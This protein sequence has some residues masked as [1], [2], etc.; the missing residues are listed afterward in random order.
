MLAKRLLRRLARARFTKPT[1]Q[2]S[3]LLSPR[4]VGTTVE[5]AE[6]GCAYLGARGVVVQVILSA[7]RL[8]EA[9]GVLR[10]AERLPL[11]LE[12]REESLL[13]P[14]TERVAAAL[15]DEARDARAHA[16]RAV[17]LRW[18]PLGRDAALLFS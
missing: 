7:G 10:A 1:T 16:R 6:G 12:G 4:S 18:M 14:A 3:G 15:G 9:R 11:A 5:A 8:V 13:I 2:A 17:D